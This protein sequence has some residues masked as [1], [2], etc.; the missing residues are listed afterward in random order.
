MPLLMGFPISYVMNAYLGTCLTL[1][2][3]INQINPP[4]LCYASYVEHPILTSASISDLLFPISACSH[5]IRY[6]LHSIVGRSYGKYIHSNLF[7]SLL[8]M[9]DGSINVVHFPSSATSH[10]LSSSP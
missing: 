2:H 10:L 5:L 8:P 7:M 3:H 1:P 6:I 4:K 9:E